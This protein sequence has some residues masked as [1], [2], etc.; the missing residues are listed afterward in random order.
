MPRKPTVSY[1]RSQ[2]QQFLAQKAKWVAEFRHER[3]NKAAGQEG[4]DTSL[5]LGPAVISRSLLFFKR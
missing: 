1:A 3:D 2:S 5:F 4:K